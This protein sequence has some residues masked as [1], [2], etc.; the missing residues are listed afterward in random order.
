MDKSKTGNFEHL[1]R[2]GTIGIRVSFGD[3][4]AVFLHRE[5]MEPQCLNRLIEQFVITLIRYRLEM[6]EFLP[7]SII[8]GL[9]KYRIMKESS[10]FKKLSVCE[11]SK[12]VQKLRIL[13]DFTTLR[14]YGWNG[15]S[16]DLAALLAPLVD[17]LSRDQKTFSQ[18]HVIRRGAGVMELKYGNLI[19]RDFMN[20]S[21]P[22]TLD[23][24]AKSCGEF[25]ISKT[26]FPYEYYSG[27]GELLSNGIFPKYRHFR[28]I[29]TKTDPKYVQEFIQIVNRKITED[30]WNT[31]DIENY[32]FCEAIPEISI[33]DGVLVITDENSLMERLHTSPAKYEESL[34]EFELNCSTMLDYL[35]RYNLRDCELLEKSIKKYAGGFLKDWNINIH[36]SMS[37]PGFAQTMC[38]EHFDQ[39]SPAIFSF[40]KSFRE[41]NQDVRANLHGGMTMVLHRHISLDDVDPEKPKE[42]FFT[43]NGQK[44]RCIESLGTVFN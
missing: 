36:E 31:S 12:L 39:S 7:K 43:D 44:Y 14:I 38:Y 27:P 26:T 9:E 3:N 30:N 42:V 24:F 34:K 20:Y 10:D 8:E 4:R 15:E 28:T 2:I 37:L 13:E 6:L 25:E 5:S 29:L 16:F 21:S 17:V 32:Y 35:E 22:M 40:G 1:H 11:K 33:E 23:A 18:M 41:F 19:F